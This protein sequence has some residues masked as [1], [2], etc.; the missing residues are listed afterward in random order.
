MTILDLNKVQDEF[1]MIRETFTY[2]EVIELI[3]YLINLSEAQHKDILRH[4]MQDFIEAK[5]DNDIKEA[6][7]YKGTGD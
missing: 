6:Q 5:K 1:E 2:S 3:R 7:R 4:Q